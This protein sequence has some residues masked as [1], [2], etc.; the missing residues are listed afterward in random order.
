MCIFS[1][2]YKP[3]MKGIT[4]FV[5]SRGLHPIVVVSNVTKR[6]EKPFFFARSKSE[7]MMSLDL[8]LEE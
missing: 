7:R 6:A 1:E 2:I 5:R 3:C 4:A 8:G